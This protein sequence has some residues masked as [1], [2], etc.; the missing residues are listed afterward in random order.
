MR[1]H[2][3]LPFALTR[4]PPTGRE[5]CPTRE[6]SARLEP[7]DL[8]AL[9]VDLDDQR[10]GPSWL[11]EHKCDEGGGAVKAM[12]EPVE[13]TDRVVRRFHATV[14][15]PVDEARLDALAMASNAGRA[16]DE[17]GAA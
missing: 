13:Q 5:C 11:E 10:R 7:A 17:G 9:H 15:D 2:P 6:E 4:D 3:V 14:G 8:E 16:V 12:S 1:P